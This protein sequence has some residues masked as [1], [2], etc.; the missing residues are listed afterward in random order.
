[1]PFFFL[2]GIHYMRYTCQV[3]Y[4]TCFLE[5]LQLILFLSVSQFRC[6]KE[7]SIE[8]GFE[9]ESALKLSVD[10]SPEMLCMNAST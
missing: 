10:I 2:V 5:K 6:L 3:N 7:A 8:I 1:V 9:Q 4:R